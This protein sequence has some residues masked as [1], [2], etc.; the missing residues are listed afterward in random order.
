[1]GDTITLPETKTLFLYQSEPQLKKNLPGKLLVSCW[2]LGRWHCYQT[3]YF[4]ALS[5]I[6]Y[7]VLNISFHL[8][9]VYPQ[10]FVLARTTKVWLGTDNL[11]LVG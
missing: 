11:Q 7:L 8:L 10:D 9:K 5:L 2:K 1:M 6:W 3:T 4:L